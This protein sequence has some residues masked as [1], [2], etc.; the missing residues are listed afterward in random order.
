MSLHIKLPAAL[1]DGRPQLPIWYAPR[2]HIGDR[3][4]SEVQWKSAH[5]TKCSRD[6][7]KKNMKFGIKSN[8]GSK[9]KMKTRFLWSSVQL[10]AHRKF[11]PANSLKKI[12]TF[13]SPGG[14]SAPTCILSPKSAVFLVNAQNGQTW[15]CASPQCL[16]GRA[17][18]SHFVQEYGY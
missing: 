14:G 11:S 17:S 7:M 9:T 12:K 2:S 1:R 3:R 8:A 16:W 4:F 13:P 10:S 15:E 18:L 5:I 6:E